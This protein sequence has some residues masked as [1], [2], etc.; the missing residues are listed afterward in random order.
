VKKILRHLALPAEAPPLAPAMLAASDGP[1]FEAGEG[2]WGASG[3]AS[4]APP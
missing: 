1:L 3:A 2:E 4:R